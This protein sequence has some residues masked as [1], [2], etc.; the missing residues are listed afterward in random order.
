M[1]ILIIFLLFS[2]NAIVHAQ[3]PSLEATIQH[4]NNGQYGYVSDSSLCEKYY[5]RALRDIDRK[6]LEYLIYNNFDYT[7]DTVALRFQKTEWMWMQENTPF[8]QTRN[9]YEEDSIV[10]SDDIPGESSCY[11]A[12]FF[13][14]KAQ[15]F[16]NDFSAKVTRIADSLER[17]GYGYSPAEFTRKNIEKYFSK[18]SIFKLDYKI[19]ENPSSFSSLKNTII[20]ATVQI[21]ELGEITAITCWDT[22]NQ[23][24]I[25]HSLSSENKFVHE[26]NRLLNKAGKINPALFKKKPISGGISIYFPFVE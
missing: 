2:I 17:I 18:E 23:G 6:N 8:V 16:G 3:T 21:N 11:D 15:K 14:Y 26:I 4:V 24:P 12:V 1:R 5:K 25:R 9:W 20:L 7:E 13:E 19:F 10:F 22:K